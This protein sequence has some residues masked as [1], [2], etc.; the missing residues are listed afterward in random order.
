MADEKTRVRNFWLSLFVAFIIQH[1]MQTSASAEPLS[2]NSRDA[3]KFTRRILVTG[4]AGFMYVAIIIIVIII[5]RRVELWNKVGQD[6][7]INSTLSSC[8]FSRAYLCSGS[9]VVILLVKKYP[10]YKI[11][12]LDKLDYCATLKNLAS[13]ESYPNYVFVKVRCIDG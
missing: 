5:S 9:H 10:T 2:P 3:I 7:S 12:N 11:V 4:G 6:Y 8:V 1:S 13:I